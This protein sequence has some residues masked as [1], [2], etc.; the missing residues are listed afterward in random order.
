MSLESERRLRLTD[1]VLHFG[2]HTSKLTSAET[3][4]QGRRLGGG[5]GGEEEEEEEGEVRAKNEILHDTISHIFIH[6]YC[7]CYIRTIWVI[8]VL[9][10]K[11][12]SF[13]MLIIKVSFTF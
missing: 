5:G 2:N 8:A 7:C 13:Q 3:Q 6:V 9:A 10:K 11:L 12:L 4:A 1:S